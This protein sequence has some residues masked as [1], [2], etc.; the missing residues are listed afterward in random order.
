MID[1]PTCAACD[2]RA[3]LAQ[4]SLVAAGALVISACGD[5]QIGASPTAPGGGSNKL[6]VALASFPALANVGG[7]ARVDG[8]SSH[9]VALV[10]TSANAFLALSMTCPHQGTR[11][12]I[13]TSGF[14]CPNHGATFDGKG[15]WI[16]G[17]ATSSLRTVASV[18]DPVAGTITI[19]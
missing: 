11:V 19:G 4:V 8:G 18:Y 14:L 2:R 10:R 16:G 7:T 9:P 3:F 1:D 13:Q 6:V 12:L 17:L 15:K 5:G